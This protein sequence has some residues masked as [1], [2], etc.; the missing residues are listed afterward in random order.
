MS[1][2]CSWSSSSLCLQQTAA[3]VIQKNC[4]MDR[5]SVVSLKRGFHV[6]DVTDSEIKNGFQNGF[7]IERSTYLTVYASQGFQHLGSAPVFISKDSGIPDCYSC[8]MS[9]VL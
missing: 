5:N 8:V 3:L 7:Q 4:A 1:Q 6:R 9:Q 2:I